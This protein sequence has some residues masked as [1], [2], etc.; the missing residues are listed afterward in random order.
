M[1]LPQLNIKDAETTRLVRELVK[2]TGETQTEAVRQALRERLER[3]T[4]ERA[5]REAHTAA[6]RR[7]EFE[8]IW[9]KVK[10]IQRRVQRR[11]LSE[12]MLTDAD[13]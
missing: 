7:R 9:T 10:K 8:T 1:T 12:N 4:A 13:L 5:A 3:A 11:G 2:M 6:G